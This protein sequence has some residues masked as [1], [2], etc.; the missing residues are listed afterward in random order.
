MFWW[1]RPLSV[2]RMVDWV[3]QMCIPAWTCAL[4]VCWVESF[5]E[6]NFSP[7]NVSQP[8]KNHRAAFLDLFRAIRAALLYVSDKFDVLICFFFLKRCIVLRRS[9]ISDIHSTHL[10]RLKCQTAE[11]RFSKNLVLLYFNHT[12]LISAVTCLSAKCVEWQ[13]TMCSVTQMRFANDNI[14]IT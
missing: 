14:R 7:N 13:I 4:Y 2:S 3:E 10:M 11:R 5:K 12:L 6:I 8:S 9:H 1:P